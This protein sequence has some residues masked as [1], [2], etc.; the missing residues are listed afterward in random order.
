MRDAPDNTDN[1]KTRIE[2]GQLIVWQW[3]GLDR[4]F[5]A[6]HEPNVDGLRGCASVGYPVIN[7]NSGLFIDVISRIIMKVVRLLLFIVRAMSEY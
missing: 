3:L 7:L 6:N 1:K 2:A 4:F 5:P